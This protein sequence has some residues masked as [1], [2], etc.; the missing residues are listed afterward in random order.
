VGVRHC[1]VTVLPW[2]PDGFAVWERGGFLILAGNHMLKHAP[3]QGRALALA[4]LGGKL[5]SMLQPDAKLGAELFET[6]RR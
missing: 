5:P 2:S 3:A 6:S 1:R 4:A